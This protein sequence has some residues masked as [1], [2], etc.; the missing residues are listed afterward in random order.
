MPISVAVDLATY[1]ALC[2]PRLGRSYPASLKD[3]LSLIVRRN[4]WLLNTFAIQQNSTNPSR[5]LVTADET[6]TGC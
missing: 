2:E 6:A 5:A 3:K 1:E 4:A